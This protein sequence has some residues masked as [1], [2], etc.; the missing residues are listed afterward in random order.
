[1]E[2]IIKR[3]MLFFT[4]FFF[5]WGSLS[6][7][8]QP[9]TSTQEDSLVNIRADLV[10]ALVSVT[11]LQGNLINTLNK[12]DFEVLEDGVVQDISSFGRESTLPLNLVL[13]FDVSASVKPR[14]KFEQQAAIKFFKEVLRPV[15]RAALMSFNHDVTIEQDFT[16]N[17]EVLTSAVRELKPKGG[18]ALYD[19]IYLASQRLEKGN[20][21]HAIVILSDGANT[22]SRASLEKALRIAERAD[23]VIYAIYTATR[24]PEEPGIVAGDKELE[25]ICERMGGEVFFPKDLTSLDTIF[26]QLAALLRAQYAVSF[27]SKNE[28]RDG[29]YRTLKVNV[30]NPNFKIGSL[31]IRTRKG[32]YAPKD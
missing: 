31:K 16:A 9:P 2:K 12:D 30:K 13:L 10:T 3:T 1:M 26:S 27:Y 24:L 32:Y 11:D 8:Q 29:N 15:D 14:L 23:A 17:I 21:R 19:A 22:I 6:V 4:L 7:A 20:G 5:S 28:D 18:T 25:K